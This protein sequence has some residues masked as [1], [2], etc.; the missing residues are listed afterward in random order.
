MIL[1][2]KNHGILNS[3]IK[4]YICTKVLETAKIMIATEEIYDDVNELQSIFKGI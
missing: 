3:K 2:G 1:I 4:E